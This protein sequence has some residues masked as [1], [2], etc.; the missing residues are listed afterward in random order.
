MLG[1]GADAATAAAL[2]G[3]LLPDMLTYSP[4]ALARVFP[5]GRGLAD[6]VADI[7]LQTLTGNPAATDCVEANG[8]SFSGKFP[9]LADAH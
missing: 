3:A 5:N 2:V 8:G 4:Q 1:L 9:Y 7:S 6:D